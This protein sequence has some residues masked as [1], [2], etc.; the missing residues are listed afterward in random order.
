M[1]FD[2]ICDKSS[3]AELLQTLVMAGQMVGAT[4]ASSLSDR[5]GRKIVHLWSN[6]LTFIFGFGVGFASNYTTLA[7]IKFMLG[8][9]QQ[10]S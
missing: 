10:V 5:M 9:F 2:L 1:Q 4:C 7:L 8:V 3:L 6:L